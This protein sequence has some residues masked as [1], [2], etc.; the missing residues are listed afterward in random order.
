MWLHLLTTCDWRY[1]NSRILAFSFFLQFLQ[2]PLWCGGFQGTH[3]ARTVVDEDFVRFVTAEL[4]GFVNQGNVLH[5]SARLDSKWCCD[6]QLWLLGKLLI[7][8]R[9]LFLP[10]SAEIR[11]GDTLSNAII[12]NSEYIQSLIKDAYVIG[13]FKKISSSYNNYSLP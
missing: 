8:R 10:T 6:Q 5:F 7:Y 1:R 12:Q 9:K 3:H 11:H 2:T 4:Q 13:T